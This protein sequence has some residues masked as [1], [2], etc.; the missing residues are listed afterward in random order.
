M[1]SIRHIH[2]VKTVTILSDF[3]RAKQSQYPGTDL[4]DSGCD[5]GTLPGVR[6]VAVVAGV[7]GDDCALGDVVDLLGDLLPVLLAAE[8]AGGGDSIEK[9]LA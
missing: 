8:Q 1:V 5:S 2:T 7:D 9:F 3:N 6:A 4:H